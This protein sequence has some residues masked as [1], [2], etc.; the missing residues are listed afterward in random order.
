MKIK[1]ILIAVIII[2][3][4]LVTIVSLSGLN[5]LFS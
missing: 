4:G 2:I 1:K 5:F 3:I